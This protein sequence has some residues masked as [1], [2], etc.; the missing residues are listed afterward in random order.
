MLF[1]TIPYVMNTSWPVDLA[2]L[3]FAQS[4]V[5][6]RVL[7]RPEAPGASNTGISP[8]ANGSPGR[9]ARARKAVTILLLLFS[10]TVSNVVFFN[11]V[12]DRV[13]YG[14]LGFQFWANLLLLAAT[15][16]LLIPSLQERK[17]REA[18]SYN[19]LKLARRASRSAVLESLSPRE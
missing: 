11:M 13:R 17:T 12:G 7:Q 15:Y 14:F 2:Y 3:P 8:G 18:A 10:I 9:T 5:A 16:A 1:L 4:L 19:S 6:W